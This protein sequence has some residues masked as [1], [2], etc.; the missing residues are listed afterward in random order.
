MKYK[1]EMIN[2]TE[3]AVTSNAGKKYFVD[4]VTTEETEARRLAVIYS[5]QWHQEQIDKMFM[6]GQRDGLFKDSACMG[7][8]LC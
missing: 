7:D 5:M 8:Y 2:E 1:A 4:T 6:A 3:W